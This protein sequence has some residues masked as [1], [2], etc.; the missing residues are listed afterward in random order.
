VGYRR[1]VP[2][3]LPAKLLAI[4]EALGA[5]QSQ[6]VKALNVKISC[7]RISEYE[8]GTREPNLLV[9]LAYARLVDVPVDT[10]IDDSIELSL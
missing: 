8:H 6:L 5:S 10:I 4:R 7:A 3:K 1:S 2:Q 9:L